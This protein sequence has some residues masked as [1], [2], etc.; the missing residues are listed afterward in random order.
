MR[1]GKPPRLNSQETEKAEAAWRCAEFAQKRQ[2]SAL[3]KS[4]FIR[5]LE[6][7]FSS[8]LAMLAM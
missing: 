1:L 7:T 5:V 3:N 4:S 6:A 8:C 2:T